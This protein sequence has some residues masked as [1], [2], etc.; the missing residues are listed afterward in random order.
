MNWIDKLHGAVMPMAL[1][2]EQGKGAVSA[3]HYAALRQVLSET[4]TNDD[5]EVF[6]SS[7]WN[8]WFIAE[9]DETREA[10]HLS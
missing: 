10:G 2:M 3:E 1:A 4:P 7:L 5:L 9:E 8:L 6:A